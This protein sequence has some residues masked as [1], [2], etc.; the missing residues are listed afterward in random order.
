MSPHTTNLPRI[1]ASTAAAGLVLASAGFGAVYAYAVGIQHGILLAGLTV[2]MALCLECVKPL[3]IHAS[4]QAF[5][6]WAPLRGVLMLA[7]GLIAVAYSLTSELALMASNR[8]DMAA[9]RAQAVDQLVL[10][11]E[12]Y[13]RSKAELA[14]LKPSRTVQ[15]LEALQATCR[16]CPSLEA[17]LARAKRKQELENA[18]M[19]S[20]GVIM[21]APAVASAD[22]GSAALTTYLAALGLKLSP[23][24]VSQWLTLVPVLALEIGSALAGLLIAWSKVSPGVSPEFLSPVSHPSTIR[25][26]VAEALLSHLKAQGVLDGSHRKL[27]QQFGTDR[28]AVGRAIEDLKRIGHVNVS[29]SKRGTRLALVAQ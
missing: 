19:A 23:S 15:E 14:A 28:N 13:D 11:K 4:V 18:M 3:A 21:T 26:K 5:Q 16:A 12:R 8:G 24:V 27:A 9:H 2:V 7:L 29:A 1:V 10:A 17:E 25:D 20:S 22:P 6:S